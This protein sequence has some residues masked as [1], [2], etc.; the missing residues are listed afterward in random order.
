MFI[1]CGR[2][3]LERAYSIPRVELKRKLN[4]GDATSDAD[5]NIGLTSGLVRDVVSFRMHSTLRTEKQR[6]EVEDRNKQVTGCS[7]EAPNSGPKEV[8]SVLLEL[9]S[10]L[11]RRV[12]S[13]SPSSFRWYN[14]PSNN[15]Q[16][17][18]KI[19]VLPCSLDLSMFAEDGPGP[20][21]VYNDAIN[22]PQNIAKTSWSRLIDRFAFHMNTEQ[23]HDQ[24]FICTLNSYC[25]RR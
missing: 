4:T 25:N 24:Q 11:H 20:N 1:R 7:A 14:I 2:V 21:D 23:H 3:A 19:S 10:L 18:C 12:L 16:E 13:Q 9:T 6:K 15:S 22:N 5:R 17:T 8:H